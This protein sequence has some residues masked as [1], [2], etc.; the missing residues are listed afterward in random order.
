MKRILIAIALIGL[1]SPAVQ[2]WLCC[3]TATGPYCSADACVEVPP[4]GTCF[5]DAGPEDAIAIAYDASGQVVDFDMEH[6]WREGLPTC[7]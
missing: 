4:D 5:T 2:A 3:A 1:L 6:C 7:L